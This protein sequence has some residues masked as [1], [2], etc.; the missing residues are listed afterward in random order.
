MALP[1]RRTKPI[2][3]PPEG[4]RLVTLIYPATF[5][6]DVKNPAG[7]ELTVPESIAEIWYANGICTVIA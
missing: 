5:P 4:K 3:P 7:V 6:D 2:E 1:A